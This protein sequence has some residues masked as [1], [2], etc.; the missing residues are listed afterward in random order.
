MVVIY[1]G[2]AYAVSVSVNSEAP[3]GNLVS[4]AGSG[5][6]SV[7]VEVMVDSV[8]RP[9]MLDVDASVPMPTR[10]TTLLKSEFT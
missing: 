6:A 1:I 5:N 7:L 9:P 4:V 2:M 8:P 3:S 10:V